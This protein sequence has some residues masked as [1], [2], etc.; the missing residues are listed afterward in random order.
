RD[1]TAKLRLAPT[2]RLLEIGCGPGNLM[3]PLSFAVE[4]ATGIDHPAVIEMAED[5]YQAPNVR[6]IGGEFP[7]VVLNGTVDRILVYSVLHIL[8]DFD[9]V[10]GFV[11]A[12]MEVLE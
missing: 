9:A 1:V 11:F 3:I 12:A 5:R 7:S 10:R 2:S 6:W 8:Q 4:H